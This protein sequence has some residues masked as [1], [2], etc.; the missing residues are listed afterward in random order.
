MR[1]RARLDMAGVGKDDE[2]AGDAL[3][4]LQQRQR[5][6]ENVVAVLGGEERQTDR[7]GERGLEVEREGRSDRR[8]EDVA[9]RWLKIGAVERSLF[10][11][12]AAPIQHERGPA[13][14][15]WLAPSGS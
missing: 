13:G 9:R 11:I 6:R 2:A 5:V 12:E 10:G 3:G 8:V 7:H 4:P 14:G 1:P 15:I